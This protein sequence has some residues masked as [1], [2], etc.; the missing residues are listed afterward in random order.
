MTKSCQW[1]WKDS[2]R[3]KAQWQEEKLASRVNM[4]GAA[5]DQWLEVPAVV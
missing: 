4:D 2:A 3:S 1:K 5:L